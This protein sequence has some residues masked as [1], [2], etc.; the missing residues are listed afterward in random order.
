MHAPSPR[1]APPDA[2]SVEHLPH[3]GPLLHRL[4]PACATLPSLRA[5]HARLLAHGLLRA[6]RARTKLLS[7][8]SAL[9]DLASARRVLDET[10]RPDAYTYRVALGWHASAGR[11]AEAVA[12]HRG[13]RRRCPEAQDD[14]VLLS[15]ALKASVRS[16]DFRYGRRLHCDAVK[17]G[18]ADGFVMNCLVDMYAKAGDLEN[19][20]KVFDRILS[21]NVVSWTSMLSGCLQ[22]GFA[23]EGLA[24]FNEMREERVLPSEHTMASVLTACTMLGS[25]HQGRWVH[26]SVIK[27]GMVFNPFVTAVM[28]DMYVKCGEVEDARRLFDELGFVDLVLWTTMIVGYTQ[29]GSPLDA[30]LLFADKK[31]V[32]IVPNSVTI[33]TVLSAS[34]QLR[35]LSLGRLIHGMSVKLGVVEKDVV[36]NALVDMYAKCKAVSEANGIFGRISNKDVVTW[37]SLIAGYVEN[38]MGNEALMLFSQM[39]VQGSSP[40][41]ISVVNALSACVC[42]GDLLI[43]KCFH[44]YAIKRAFLSNIY[45]NTALLNLYNK[46]ADLPSAQRVFSEMND[47][48]SVTWGAMIGGYGMQ[49]DSAGSI[50]LFNEMLKDNIQPNEVVF[51]SILSTCSHTGMVSVG[52]K[53]FESMAQYFNITPSMK[54]YACM[55]DVLSRAGNLEEALDFIQKMPMQADISVWGAFLHGCKLH[56]RL[57]FGEEAINRMMVPHPDT[58]AFYVL[59][60]N[61]YTSYGRWDK[62]LAI[63]RSM[64]ERGLVK[65]PGCSSVGLENG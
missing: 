35:N 19:A 64:Q 43:G 65:L 28:L 52:K 20:R 26:G 36:M 18:G 3:G 25:L 15:L 37:N 45:V 57:E 54:H 62:S 63:R 47:R 4:L 5:L 44:T 34:A 6:L 56:S 53:C 38:D 60:S 59:M 32:R 40:D 12:L 14:V 13:M 16:A 39:R 61:L 11:H 2:H 17:A 9:G 31:F 21:R 27:H 50:D 46:C 51:T 42:L 1:G 23:E 24:L 55:V 48:N 8:Y 7:C 58:P 29:N 30:L 49:G 41:A 22:N 33:A 10:P